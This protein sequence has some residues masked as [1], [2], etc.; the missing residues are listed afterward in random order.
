[1]Q[2][3]QEMLLDGRIQNNY[4]IIRVIDVVSG[5]KQAVLLSDHSDNENIR[6]T[7]KCLGEE[8]G[9]LL[10]SPSLSRQL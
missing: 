4:E 9:G 2:I 3:T 6:E 7:V 8:G 10:Q 5:M 1:M